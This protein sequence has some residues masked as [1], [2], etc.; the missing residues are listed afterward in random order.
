MKPLYLLIF[1][2]F[3]FS[4]S[5]QNQLGGDIDGEAINDR[6]GYALSLSSDG[7]TVAIGA[8]HNDG[9][10]SDAGHVRIYE[11]SAGS[12]TQLGA[13]IDGEAMDDLSGCAVSLSS[14]GTIVA[15]GAP[16]NDGTGGNAGH[17]RVYELCIS[18][19]I[20]QPV[21]DTFTTVPGDAYFSITYSDSAATYLWQQ[22]DNNGWLN[23]SD[24]G[25][26]SGTM[27]DSLVLTGITSS[28]NGFEYR[29]IINGCEID[30]SDIAILTVIDNIGLNDDKLSSVTLSP[31]PNSGLFSIQVEQ[32]HIGSSYQIL[33]N[34]GRLIDKGIIRD[35]SQDFDLSDKPKGV[36]RIQVSN[37]KSLKTVNVV[38]K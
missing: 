38:I 14:D 3:S 24:T 9:M 29:C 8:I 37:E 35:L 4:V 17:V 25:I 23:L 30:T 5:A 1:F 36:Y 18:S 31:N 34:L 6:S 33:D 22:N 26:Y 20:Q 11:Y 16:Y 19:N 21:S 2:F 7:T 13:D 15:I 27:T 10:G 12:W 32:E 28:L